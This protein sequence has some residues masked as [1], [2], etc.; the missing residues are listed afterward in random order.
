MD[1]LRRLRGHGV[2]LFR[3]LI[4]EQ[5][6]VRLGR[7][8]IIVQPRDNLLPGILERRFHLGDLRLQLLHSRVSWSEGGT[9][10]GALPSEIDEL[11]FV[12]AKRGIIQHLRQSLRWTGLDELESRL[13][14]HA[15]GSCL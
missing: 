13:R 11:G 4:V 15:L 6:F 10:L 2:Q 14:D 5:F 3:K 8:V 9:Q 12:L 1:F 7:S